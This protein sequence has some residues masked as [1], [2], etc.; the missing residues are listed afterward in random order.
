MSAFNPILDTCKAC[1]TFPAFCCL[2]NLLNTPI[3]I[4]SII[5]SF[6]LASYSH[7]LIAVVLF[8]KHCMCLLGLLLLHGYYHTFKYKFTKEANHRTLVYLIYTNWTGKA[9][10][11]NSKT[12]VQVK[13]G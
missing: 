3:L 13:G 11:E 12:R 1:L 7:L 2:E 4:L 8:L 9:K 6:L 5:L 10:L